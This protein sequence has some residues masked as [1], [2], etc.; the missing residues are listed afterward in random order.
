MNHYDVPIQPIEYIEANGLD[1]SEGNVIKY[2]T[3]Y[4]D[5][6]GVNDLRKAEYYI[7]KLIER[8]DKG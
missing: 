7:K 8:Y 2:V 6:G 3:R 4:K 5:K 1:F